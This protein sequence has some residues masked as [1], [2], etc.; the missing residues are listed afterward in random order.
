ML[1]LSVGGAKKKPSSAIALVLVGMMNAFETLTAALV[2]AA[3][4]L[5][6]F[7]LVVVFFV[8]KS[9]FQALGKQSKNSVEGESEDQTDE[10]KRKT[11]PEVRV[12]VHVLNV[13]NINLAAQTFTV[14][15]QFEAS[16]ENRELNGKELK[17]VEWEWDDNKGELHITKA[18][19]VS[20]SKTGV[21]KPVDTPVDSST[22]SPVE[23][24]VQ[25][26]PDQEVGKLSP[27][28]KTGDGTTPVE[29]PVDRKFFAP[30][31]KLTNLIAKVNEEKWFDFYATE[32]SS[33]EPG[34]LIVCYK[35]KIVQAT[36]QE[37]MELPLFPFDEQRLQIKLLT[38]WSTDD[39]ENSV[40]LVQNKNSKYRSIVNTD[41]FLQSSEYKLFDTL[42]F[43]SKYTNSA[44][45]ASNK[46]YS[47][48]H[49]SM[50]VERRIGYWYTNV[51]LPLFIVTS[52]VLP[53]YA[54]PPDEFG[55]RASILFTLLLAQ[56]AYKHV[57]AEKLPNISYMTL[58]DCYVF[59]CF[60]AT[61]IVVI[62]QFCENR[63]IIPQLVVQCSNFT[64]SGCTVMNTSSVHYDNPV[65]TTPT[66]TIT[67]SSDDAGWTGIDLSPPVREVELPI[68][69]LWL[70]IFWF[71]GHVLGV[72]AFFCRKIWRH[73]KNKS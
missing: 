50:L 19:S 17:N 26:H 14:D 23:V 54:V 65:S 5:A 66:P 49:C 33:G 59:F 43:E 8:F 16:W 22:N 63:N 44:D 27:K 61:F 21:E 47:L 35:W 67:T 48:L 13:V 73:Q 68:Y 55:D 12:R 32:K 25:E 11:K 40:Q 15:V 56:V 60:A 7:L 45:S 46:K 9:A 37:S 62:L 58:L 30:R 69:F 52:C 31:L 2:L 71:G 3:L 51:M 64:M 18:N 38:G 24:F 10:T 70:S 6:F 34:P 41:N 57:I 1:I 39:E 72:C 28:V 42:K 4:Q 36:F 53:S 29:T 20:Q